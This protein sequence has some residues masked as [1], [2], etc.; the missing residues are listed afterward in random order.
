M[1]TTMIVVLASLAIFSNR[2]CAQA[3]ANAQMHGIVTD[4]SGALIPNAQIKATQTETGQVRNTVTGVDG[5]YVL[6]NL[7]VGP[8]TVEATAPGFKSYVQ[9][10][11][12]LQVGNNVQVNVELQVG[13]IS[14]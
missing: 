6:P 2:V 8:Y 9:S 1:R 4:T 3:V 10:G 7:A 12:T 5:G 13:A 11:I 14:Q